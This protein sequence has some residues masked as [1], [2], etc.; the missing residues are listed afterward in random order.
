MARRTP[1]PQPFPVRGTPTGY[2]DIWEADDSA[3]IQAQF[4][5]RERLIVAAREAAA[6]VRRGKGLTHSEPF[7]PILP[8]ES[9]AGDPEQRPER[10]TGYG[11]SRAVDA[12][13]AVLPKSQ[14]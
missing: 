2:R 7:P 4:A 3:I 6:T 11:T 13:N 14:D 10:R 12:G 1:A 5:E 8:A 9:I